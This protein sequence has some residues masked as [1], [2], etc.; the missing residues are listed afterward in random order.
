MMPRWTFT[1][2]FILMPNFCPSQ[3]VVAA[4]IIP[5]QGIISATQVVVVNGELEGTYASED[6]VIGLEARI[7]IY[8]GRPIRT[9]DLQHPTIV[10][11]NEIV[12]LRYNIGSLL[13]I[14][15]GRALDRAG[16]GE[17]I[18][19]Q[20]TTSRTGLTGVVIGPGLISV[21]H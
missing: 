21:N 11:R 7:N 8:P 19:V 2:I 20:N 17:R 1:I 6:D 3:V 12:T 14:T 13:I 4:E 18:R 5:S 10:E 16:T 15:E 9:S